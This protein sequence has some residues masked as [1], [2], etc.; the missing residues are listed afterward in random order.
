LT[1]ATGFRFPSSKE[2]VTMKPLSDLVELFE[3]QHKIQYF[4]LHFH[5]ATMDEI[6]ALRRMREAE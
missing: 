4:G 5:H 6:K 3:I 1:N 2:N